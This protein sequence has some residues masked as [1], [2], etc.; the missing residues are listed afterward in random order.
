MLWTAVQWAALSF[1]QIKKQPTGFK[2]EFYGGK[3]WQMWIVPISTGIQKDAPFLTHIRTGIRK[4][5]IACQAVNGNVVLIT[6]AEVTRKKDQRR[7]DQIL[8][9]R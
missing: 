5:I 3:S 8:I 4:S 1:G 7:F 6:Q 9:Y 2:R